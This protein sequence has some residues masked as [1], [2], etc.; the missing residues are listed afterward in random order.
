MKKS[1]LVMKSLVLAGALF[2]V[3]CNND[4]GIKCPEP[5]TGELSPAETDFSGTWVFT[6]MEAEDAIDITDDNTDNPSTDIFAQQS[7]CETDLVYNFSSDRNYSLKQGYTA[8]DCNNKQTLSGTWSLSS[9]N[10]LTFI[11]NC[12]LQTTNITPSETGDS[13]SFVSTVTFNEASGAVKSTK[14][15]FTYTKVIEDETP[16]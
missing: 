14:V 4:D 8:E 10:V 15:T 7:E 12:S 1:I 5:L 11:A 16:Q 9:E 13:F 2:F 6:A 3:G